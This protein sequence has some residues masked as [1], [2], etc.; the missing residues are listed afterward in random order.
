M[1]R[2]LIFE[3][4][5]AAGSH[6]PL[7]DEAKQFLPEGL[8]MTLAV[9]EDFTKLREWTVRVL[10]STELIA[11]TP[12]QVPWAWVDVQNDV[13]AVLVR[14]AAAADWTLVIAPE[15][16]GILQR[17]AQAVIDAGGTLLGP[18][19]EFIAL[20]SDKTAIL[21]RLAAY[22]LRVPRG[23]CGPLS[24]LCDS[25]LHYPI[26]LKP[27]DG[28]GAIDTM[29]LQK[30]HNLEVLM[31]L[32]EKPLLLDPRPFIWRGE[33][34]VPGKAASVS[35][36]C[37][38]RDKLPLRPVAQD[39]LFAENKHISYRGGTINLSHAEETRAKKLGLAVSKALPPVIGYIGIDLILGEAADGSQDTVIEVNPR[40][41]TSYIGLRRAT[42]QSL[43]DAM[44]RIAQGETV[45]I[46]W[47][48]NIV[49]FTKHGQVSLRERS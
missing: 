13:D 7:S 39:I 22:D 9:A 19:P 45:N 31:L 25:S 17:R 42:H 43:A 1:P 15:C 2:L 46:N 23:L 47:L 29:L 5:L 11:S 3:E 14:E 28:A 10:R 44:W 37:G 6:G 20:A 40:L 4:C 21:D 12:E 49:E 34:F 8:A 41:T 33:E 18:S 36:L 38:P 16:G 35:L 24:K 27:N 48:P 26:V 30:N 32:W